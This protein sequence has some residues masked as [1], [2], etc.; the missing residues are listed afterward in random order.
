MNQMQNWHTRPI[1]DLTVKR[2]AIRC[3]YLNEARA[4]C[5]GD[6]GLNRYIEHRATSEDPG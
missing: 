2:T 5:H 4:E 6:A 1:V 3:L